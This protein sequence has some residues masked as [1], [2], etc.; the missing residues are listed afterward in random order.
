MGFR[1]VVVEVVVL[2][3]W[4]IVGLEIED[5][6]VELDELDE[7]DEVEVLV[8]LVDVV[9]EDVLLRVDDGEVLE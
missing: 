4:V 6:E 8:W 5:D 3:G 7:L 2:G 1:T 9:V